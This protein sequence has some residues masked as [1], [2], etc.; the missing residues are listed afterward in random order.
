[1]R[2]IDFT[3]NQFIKNADYRQAYMYR[4]RG[5]RLLYG[6]FL[7]LRF[8]QML[9]KALEWDKEPSDSQYWWMMTWQANWHRF[10]DHLAKG[11]SAEAFFAKLIKS[12]K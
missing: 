4:Q 1:M 8:W 2:P 7:T 5:S 11:K 10:I 9:G 3:V 6:G 12:K